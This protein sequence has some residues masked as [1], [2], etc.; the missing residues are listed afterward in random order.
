MIWPSYKVSCT[1]RI[2]LET[3]WASYLLKNRCWPE[4]CYILCNYASMKLLDRENH[5]PILS[6]DYIAVFNSEF[7]EVFRL[8]VAVVLRVW[9]C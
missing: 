9:I 8:N 2:D 1:S 3:L 5:V 4:V 6:P 7:L